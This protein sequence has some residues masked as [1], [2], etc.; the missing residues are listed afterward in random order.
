MHLTTNLLLQV[1]FLVAFQGV[2]LT[3]LA[4]AI[5][6]IVPGDEPTN[7]L[8]TPDGAPANCIAEPWGEFSPTYVGGSCAAN[9]GGA[10]GCLDDNVVSSPF[11][12]EPSGSQGRSGGG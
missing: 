12:A 4:H 3:S 6:I 7:N 11:L 5:A 10:H 2:L 8:A 1:A 9:V